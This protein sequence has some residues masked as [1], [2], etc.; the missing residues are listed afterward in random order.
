MSIDKDVLKSLKAYPV[1][2]DTPLNDLFS[3]AKRYY[4]ALGFVPDP[5]Y[6]NIP[7]NKKRLTQEYPEEYE[8]YCNVMREIARRFSIHYGADFGEAKRIKGNAK[9]IL[10][11]LRRVAQTKPSYEL[12]DEV[13]RVSNNNFG[14]MDSIIEKGS[15]E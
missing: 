11:E 14:I 3:D 5:D 13:M 10:F 6:D 1:S 15:I 9:N 8:H 7:E 2:Q 4:S 12:V